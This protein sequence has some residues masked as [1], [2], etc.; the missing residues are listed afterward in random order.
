M[1]TCTLVITPLSSLVLSS[2]I[3]VS[4]ALTQSGMSI[5]P[6][7]SHASAASLLSALPPGVSSTVKSGTS[8]LISGVPSTVLP[9]PLSVFISAV[10]P[11]A[12][13]LTVVSRPSASPSA[14]VRFPA[15]SCVS[16][17]FPCSSP[18]VPSSDHSLS[19]LTVIV[20][21][22]VTGSVTAEES[23]VSLGDSGVPSPVSVRLCADSSAN[24]AAPE[25]ALS[26]IASTSTQDRSFK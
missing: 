4:S 7:S 10:P 15:S 26:V 5:V 8:V 22:P 3:H 23:A 24:A 18:L 21:S 25:K 1:L 11:S 9:E 12:L 2:L 14:L 19:K 6:S 13:P 16:E 17:V 20:V